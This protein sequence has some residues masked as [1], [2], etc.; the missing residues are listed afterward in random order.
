MLLLA[1]TGA[2]GV[3]TALDEDAG[4]PALTDASNYSYSLAIDIRA[5]VFTPSEDGMLDWGNLTRDLQGFPVGSHGRRER[6][7]PGL[8]SRLEPRPGQRSHR[9]RGARPIVGRPVGTRHT[10]T[11]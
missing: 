6:A 2:P 9:H 3:D 4:V 11:R 7:R 8:V 10:R 5:I 1:C